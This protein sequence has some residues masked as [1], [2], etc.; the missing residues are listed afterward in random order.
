MP[1]S[2]TVKEV[3]FNFKES[4][5]Q[6]TMMSAVLG[7]RSQFAVPIRMERAKIILASKIIGKDSC[8]PFQ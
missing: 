2:V 3:S 8:S 5:K 7:A 1:H 6:V 4:W